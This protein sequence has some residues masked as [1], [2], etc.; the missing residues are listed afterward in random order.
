MA[1]SRGRRI[2]GGPQG[3]DGAGGAGEQER[4]DVAIGLHAQHAGAERGHRRAELAA[5]ADPAVDGR[6]AL[7]AGSV[8][9]RT[10]GGTAAIQS[11]P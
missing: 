6:A 3:G 11:S 8:V 10:V 4:L 9:R 1:I 5:G 2:A 7:A